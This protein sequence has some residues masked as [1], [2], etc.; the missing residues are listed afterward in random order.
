MK[1]DARTFVRSSRGRLSS[2]SWVPSVLSASPNPAH[3]DLAVLSIPAYLQ[4]VAPNC[5]R[6]TVITQNVDVLSTR[7]Y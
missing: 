5:T 6:Y 4:A 7:A 3:Y 2:F 1:G